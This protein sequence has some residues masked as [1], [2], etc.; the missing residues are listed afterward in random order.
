MVKIE[1]RDDDIVFNSEEMDIEAWEIEWKNAK[2]RLSVDIPDHDCPYD[3]ISCFADDLCTQC[4][5][6]KVQDQY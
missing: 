2:R 5:I 3:E 1:N 4:Q 6:D